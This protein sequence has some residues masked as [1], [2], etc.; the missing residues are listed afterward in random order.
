MRKFQIILLTFMLL[1]FISCSNA[2]DSS[3]FGELQP[4]NCLDSE[5]ILCFTSNK[6]RLALDSSMRTI[7]LKG[8]QKY[9]NVGGECNEAGFPANRIDWHVI[10]EASKMVTVNS[11]GVANPAAICGNPGAYEQNLRGPSDSDGRGNVPGVCVNG[12]YNLRINL[13]YVPS[14]SHDLFLCI[15][16]GRD[17]KYQMGGNTLNINLEKE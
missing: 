4:Q 7:H 1:N 9:F 13:G 15:S 8:S 2:V 17:G 14:V 12:R 5:D 16:C 10:E 11:F 3:L 6:D